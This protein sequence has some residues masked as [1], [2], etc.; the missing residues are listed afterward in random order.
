[1]TFHQ[2]SRQRA[3]IALVQVLGLAVWFSASA[4]APSL[5]R[6]WGISPA[7]AVWLTASVQIGFVAGAVASALLNLAD[8]FRLPWMLACCTA[9][10]AAATALMAVFA[11][12]LASGMA[13]RFLTGA[14]LAGVYPVGM[15]LM[16]SW[17][18]PAQRGKS[19]GL[20]LCAL[21]LGSALPHLIN[22]WTLP[23]RSVILVSAGI[24]LAG[25]LI[26][27]TMLKTGPHCDENRRC[28]N[29]Q[30][31]LR[32]FTEPKPLLINLGYFGHMWELYAFWTWLPTVLAASQEL[33]A[34][35][36]G[37]PIALWS[38]LAIGVFGGVGCLLGGWAADRWGRPTAAAVALS[39]SGLCC[40]LSPL[41]L[42]APNGLIM[43]FI[44]V[45]GAAVI[46]DSGIFST[47]LSETVD[48]RHVGTALTAQTAVGFLL[49]VVSIQLVPL[50]AQSL[51]WNFAL[52]ILAVGP[53]I[54]VVAM[55]K[56]GRKH[57]LTCEVELSANEMT[58]ER[59]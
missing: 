36:A 31:L 21:T 38:F 49:T 43:V 46:A 19:F 22:G 15:K 51:S 37:P 35:P 25:A 26:S 20:L 5:Q 7:A 24:A 48:P 47:A 59:R 27:G 34:G 33:A 2:E 14:F 54:A 10:A 9:G 16:A 42:N 39:I 13:Y 56:L 57:P 55:T 53:L 12:D 23:W 40:L 58:G 50:A 18:R 28:K 44:F 45:W 4:I 6:E 32:M 11:S 30:Y 1:M 29:P 52:M 8:R 41:M 17:A 3:L